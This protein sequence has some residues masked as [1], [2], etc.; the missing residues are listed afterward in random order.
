VRLSPSVITLR[1][2]PGGRAVELR[3]DGEFDIGNLAALR[4]AL[5]DAL[6]RA[7]RTIVD[8]SRC[9]LVDSTVIALLASV[10]DRIELVLPSTHTPVQTAFETTGTLPLFTWRFLA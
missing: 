6:R 5:D 9:T 1:E 3:L 10:H 8:L 4:S 7:S 2:L